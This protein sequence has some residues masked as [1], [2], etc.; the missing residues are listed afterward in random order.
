MSEVDQR[1]FKSLVFFCKP[2]CI[3]NKKQKNI[4]NIAGIKFEEDLLTYSWTPEYLKLFV[5]NHPREY[6]F[7]KTAPDVKKGVVDPMILSEDELLIKMC[8]SPILIRR[9]LMEFGEQRFL[10]FDWPGLLSVLGIDCDK[11]LSLVNIDVETCVRR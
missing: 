7:N 6:W 8:E 10:G 1:E 9:P 3:N 2:T 4:L 11:T 5:M